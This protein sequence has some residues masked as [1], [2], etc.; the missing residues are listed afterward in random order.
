MASIT[1]ISTTD[2]STYNGGNYQA[3]EG[4]A[5]SVNGA[6]IY[7]CMS[8]VSGVGVVKSINNGSTWN[9][10]N[11]TGSFRSIC[12]SS[13]GVIVY[14][15]TLGDGLYKSTDSGNSWNKF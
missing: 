8:G 10:V 6:I 3:M 4:V 12:C 1:P 11:T 2:F 14:A 5:S 7:V 9:V 15:V 13:N